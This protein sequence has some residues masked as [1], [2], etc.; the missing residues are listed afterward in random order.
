MRTRCL[1]SIKCNKKKDNFFYPRFFGVTFF[2]AS[3]IL[4]LQQGAGMHRDLN[5]LCSEK[6]LKGCPKCV[7]SFFSHR[8]WQWMLVM[9]DSDVSILYLWLLTFAFTFPWRLA[10]YLIDILTCLRNQVLRF[11]RLFHLEKKTCEGNN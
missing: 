10:A 1:I 6:T 9:F 2:Y 3:R 7:L 8:L 11:S 5:E 4:N